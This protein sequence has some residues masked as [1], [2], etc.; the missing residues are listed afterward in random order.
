MCAQ[1]VQLAAPSPEARK[2]TTTPKS[3]DEV[4]SPNDLPSKRVAEWQNRMRSG[5]CA[6]MLLAKEK[7]EAFVRHLAKFANVISRVQHKERERQQA[8]MREKLAKRIERQKAAGKYR[9]RSTV[10]KRQ[11]ALVRKMRPVTFDI[12]E[13][14]IPCSSNH[15][16]SLPPNNARPPCS[17]F[18]LCLRTREKV[19]LTSSLIEYRQHAKKKSR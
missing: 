6:S 5:S 1:K 19:Y 2:T 15:S 13:G 14:D 4:K 11:K 18:S 8:I 3:L 17:Q 10:V 12:C 9:K 16:I 7:S